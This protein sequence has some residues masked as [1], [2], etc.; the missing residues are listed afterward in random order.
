MKSGECNGICPK[1]EKG[2]GGSRSGIEE[3]LGGDE[4]VCR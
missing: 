3:N 1:D 4:E 2:S